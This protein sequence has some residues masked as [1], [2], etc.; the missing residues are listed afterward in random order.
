MV[1]FTSY[2]DIFGTGGQGDYMQIYQRDQGLPIG[3]PVI[4]PSSWNFYAQTNQIS[5]RTFTITSLKDLDATDPNHIIPPSVIGNSTYPG[6]TLTGTNANDG[7]FVIQNDNC[8]GA[9]LNKGQSCTFQIVFKATGMAG[10]S[11]VLKVPINDDR[12]AIDV[13]LQGKTIVSYLPF[14]QLY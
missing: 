3:N 5:S 9:T 6:L 8:S 10:K 7:T 1:S 13:S 12:V 2:V 4:Q 14:F 11:A